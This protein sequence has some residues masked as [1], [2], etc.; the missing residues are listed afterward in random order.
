MKREVFLNKNLPKVSL[1]LRGSFRQFF[2][3]VA[4]RD[5]GFLCLSALKGGCGHGGIQRVE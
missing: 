4:G 1:L 5:D 2:N 3:V